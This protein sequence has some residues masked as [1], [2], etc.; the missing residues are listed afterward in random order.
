MREKNNGGPITGQAISLKPIREAAAFLLVLA[1]FLLLAPGRRAAADAIWT[2]DD[3]F[4]EKHYEDCEYIGRAYYANGADG[5][6]TVVDS[7]LNRNVIDYLANGPVLY[8]YITYEKGNSGKWGLVQYVLD[9]EGQPN[10]DYS[11]EEEAA[12]GWIKMEELLNVY[13]GRSFAEEHRSEIQEVDESAA[14]KVVMPDTGAIYLWEYPGSDIS[15]GKLESLESEP[16][17]DQTYQDPGGDLW[18]H[19]GYYFGY[20]D[21]WINLSNPGEA[22]PELKP[23]EAPKLTP[24]ADRKTLESLPK[25]GRSGMELPLTVAGLIILTIVLTVL[26]I[27]FMAVKKT[28]EEKTPDSRK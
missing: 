12:V 9:E 4:Y 15:Y 1:A 11:G 24:P 8:V 18:G 5:Y 22:N 21:F 14:P 17:I 3:S 10:E 26:A 2:P 20:R 25:T 16:A 7:P 19:T 28:G 6:V 13:D 27:R 23:K